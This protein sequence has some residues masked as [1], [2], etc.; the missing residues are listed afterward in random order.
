MKGLGEGAPL[1]APPPTKKV[2]REKKFKKNIEISAPE[3]K[4]GISGRE[5]HIRD[6]R[7]RFLPCGFEITELG[8]KERV[9]IEKFSRA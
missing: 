2:G 5:Y 3:K 7:R 1:L 4:V 6:Q 9:T 8:Q